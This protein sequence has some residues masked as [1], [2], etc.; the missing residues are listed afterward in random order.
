V[1]GAGS[2]LH[3]TRSFCCDCQTLHEADLRADGAAVIFDVHCP[4]GVKSVLV[5]SDVETFRAI[6]GKS[7]FPAPPIESARSFTWANFIEITKECNCACAICFSVS[8]PGAG[9]QMSLDEVVQVA[10][11]LKQK[12]LCAVTLSG[13][14][15]T[16]HPDLAEIIAGIRALG[17]D[18]T[19]ASNGLRI[20]RD[21][22]LA[23]Q[24]RQSGVTY[25]YL[26]MDTLRA[27]VCR[28]MRGDDFVALKKQAIANARRAGLRFGFNTTVIRDNL[29]EAGDVL[30]YA[31]QQAPHLGVV[32]YLSAAPAGRFSLPEDTTVNREDIIA[33]LVRSGVVEGLSREHFWPFPRFAPF[34]LDVH[35]D[36]AALLFLAVTPGRLRPLDRF[37]N[38]PRLYRL[39]RRAS[40]RFNR[41][42]GFVL[43][44]LY[45]ALCI[46]PS[47]LPLV[48]RMLLG[49][50]TKRGSH[51]IMVVSVEQFL[52]RIYQDQERLDRCTTCNVRP[53]GSKVSTCIFEH[54]DPR[55]SPYARSR[56]G[57]GGSEHG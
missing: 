17:M 24:L 31:A 18:V 15:P 49:M 45:L 12:G 51:S 38:I 11:S 1:N 47:K 52:G 26:Q 5:S 6:R 20:G 9:A 10:R 57:L 55:R 53:D 42:W 13:G 48:L 27:E 34:A 50:L 41:V 43:L 16:L 21:Q 36:C 2:F 54:P 25:L 28:K 46:R 40:G 39:M 22:D 32:G 7:A 30:R 8:G 4:N 23:R 3:R 19:V 44:S 14:E 37:V 29:D 56:S 33:S 35:P